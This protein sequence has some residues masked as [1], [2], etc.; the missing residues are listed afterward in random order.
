MRIS[1]YLFLL[2]ILV[3]FLIV[4]AKRYNT[5]LR[6]IDGRSANEGN[7]EV[8]HEGLWRF[9]CDDYWDIRDAKVVCRQLRFTKAIMATS[10]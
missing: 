5:T 7:V 9:I 4:L 6:L 2:S 8:F 10:M 1:F 3:N